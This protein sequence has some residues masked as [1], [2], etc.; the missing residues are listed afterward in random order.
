M[1]ELRLGEPTIKQLAAFLERYDSGRQPNVVPIQAKGSKPPFFCVD[2]GPRHLRLA[3]RL[4]TDRPF[5]GLLCPK[6]IA[7]SIEVIAEFGVKSIRAAQPNGP[8][9]VDG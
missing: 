9:F 5:L 8:Y 6:P 3:Q 7:T 1:P 4:A 2:A